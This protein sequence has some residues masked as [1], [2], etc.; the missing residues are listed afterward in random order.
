MCPSEMRCC[1]M[2]VSSGLPGKSGSV[3]GVSLSH[4]CPGDRMWKAGT[5]VRQCL[6]GWLKPLQ[7]TLTGEHLE[8][9][10]TGE[11]FASASQGRVALL[12]EL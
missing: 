4:L 10:I 1:D 12:P 2:K 7:M 3:C 8:E 9:P 11:C 5:K 6:W